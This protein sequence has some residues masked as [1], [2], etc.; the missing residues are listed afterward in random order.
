[1]S[2]LS[3]ISLGLGIVFLALWYITP[4]GSH[5]ETVEGDMVSTRK[6]FLVL[7]VVSL[8]VWLAS[9]LDFFNCV[10]CNDG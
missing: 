7:A 4:K 10:A 3:T 1:M 6:V 2:A 5:Y 8:C 9:E